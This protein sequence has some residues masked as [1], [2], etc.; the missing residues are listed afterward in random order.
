[1]KKEA[2]SDNEMTAEEKR[3]YS[4]QISVEEIG[5]L[6]QARLLSSKV[7]IIGCGALGSMV[8]MQLAAAGVGS[9]VIADF[10]TIDISNLQ[11]QF[12]FSTD[13]A[14]KMKSDV[15]QE[16][17]ISINPGCKIQK[18]AKLIDKKLAGEL[19]RDCDFIIDSTDNPASKAM[20]E[21][22]C[23]GLGK[24]CCIGGVSGFH[25]QVMTV[26][27]GGMTFGDLFCEDVESDFLPCSISGVIGPA[28]AL[29]ASVQAAEAI[30]YLTGV[31]ETLAGKILTFDL[32]S[33]TFQCMNLTE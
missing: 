31:G 9:I 14:G 27:P 2:K 24:P 29:C 33:D 11:R 19:F 28:A 26:E 16:R 10:D 17:M 30:K 21:K 7:A 5:E 12:F 8:A 4:R 20:I 18:V 13:E 32:L 23:L 22:T 15:L 3:R 1:M 25:G 6:G